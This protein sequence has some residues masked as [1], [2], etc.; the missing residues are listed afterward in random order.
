M[1]E[2]YPGPNGDWS[3]ASGSPLSMFI[4]AL[5][6]FLSQE[7]DQ[8]A[9]FYRGLLGSNVSASG[10]GLSR[11]WAPEHVYN[12]ATLELYLIGSSTDVS[13]SGAWRIR[14]GCRALLSASDPSPVGA[15]S[16]LAW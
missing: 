6:G 5:Y 11:R 7:D 10:G 12:E 3:Q 8:A 14:R 1:S 15:L 4:S 9:P 13:P 2:K 16:N